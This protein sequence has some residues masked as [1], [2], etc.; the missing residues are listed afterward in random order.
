MNCYFCETG[1]HPGAMHLNV[2]HAVGICHDCGV[3]VCADHGFR[4]EAGAPLLC[5]DC[6][7]RRKS[8]ERVDLKVVGMNA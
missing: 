6:A 1:P 7:A 2:S 5:S 3:G 4:E 8:A